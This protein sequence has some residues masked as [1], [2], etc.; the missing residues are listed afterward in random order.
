[1]VKSSV[2]PQTVQS[3]VFNRTGFTVC[4]WYHCLAVDEIKLSYNAKN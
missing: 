4:H 3:K 2:H 1:M